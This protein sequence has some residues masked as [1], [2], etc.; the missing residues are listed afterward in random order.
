MS[1]FDTPKK[2]VSNVERRVDKRKIRTSCI[3]SSSTLFSC[4][5]RAMYYRVHHAQINVSCWSHSFLRL[6]HQFF[7]KNH[8]ENIFSEKHINELY[9]LIGNHP[10]VINSINVKDSV[11]VKINSTLV[12]KQKHI[13]Q[14]S[15]R[16]LHN[17]MILSSSEGGFPGA[18]KIDGNICIEY[19]SLRNYMSKF[20]KPTSNRNKITRGCKT[21]KKEMLLKSD[22]NKWRI[23][24]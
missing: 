5:I 10:H 20:I 3:N 9:A 22:L 17:D 11:F 14:I 4:Y 21:C 6:T 24:Q 18:R 8:Y 1:I 13:F 23:S 16:E 2:G 12:K 15:V 7:Q 19:T